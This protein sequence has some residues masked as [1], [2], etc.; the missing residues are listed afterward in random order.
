VGKQ[1]HAGIPPLAEPPV[2]AK[3]TP[4]SAGAASGFELQLGAGGGVALLGGT[5]ATARLEIGLGSLQSHWQGRIG[6]QGQTA[7]QT[8]LSTLGQVHWRHSMATVSLGWRML[9]PDW[10]VSA[11]AGPLLGF[12]T[13]SGQGFVWIRKRTPWS[14]AWTLDCV[15][16]GVGGASPVADLRGE[17]WLQHQ[18]AKVTGSTT[19]MTASP[20]GSG[21]HP[22]SVGID[23][24]MMKPFQLSPH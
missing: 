5:A 2:I 19:T 1:P 7:R 17:S 12:A 23:L 15:R 4:R 18:R 8:A 9:D 6:L 22:G 13:I 11:D 24:P 10:L 16:A 14:S 20:L 3:P 21:S